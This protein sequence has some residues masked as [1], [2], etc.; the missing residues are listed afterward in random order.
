MHELLIVPETGEEESAGLKAM[1]KDV[2][3]TQLDLDEL[4]SYH[5]YY[6]DG[7]SITKI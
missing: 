6:F 1:V 5:I 7:E 2:N 4:L 3:D